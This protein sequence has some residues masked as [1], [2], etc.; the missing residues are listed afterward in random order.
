MKKLKYLMVTLLSVALFI[1]VGTLSAC[2]NEE[3]SSNSSNIET[4]NTYIEINPLKVVLDV[5]EQQ[6]LQATI[7]KGADYIFEAVTWSIADSNIAT[8]SAAGVV[9]AVSEGTTK[10]TAKYGDYEADCEIVVSNSGAKANLALADYAVEMRV[11]ETKRMA[12]IIRFKGASYTDAKFSY[13]VEDE[14]V[15]KISKSGVIEALQYGDTKV[16]VSASWRGISG[17]D[18]SLLTKEFTIKVKDDIHATIADNAYVVYQNDAEIEGVKFSNTADVEYSLTWAED[19]IKEGATLT[20]YSSDESVLRVENGKLFGVRAGTADVYCSYLSEKGDEYISNTVSVQ[21]IFPVLDKTEVMSFTIDKTT[22]LTGQEVFGTNVD[23]K[24]IECDGVSVSTEKPGAIDFD[25]MENGEHIITVY[26]EGYGYKVH[27]Y[28]CTAV[29]RTIA[30]LKA[31][32]YK[33]KNIGGGNLYALG[34]DIDGEGAVIDGASYGWS[35][36]SGFQGEIDGRGH[37]ISNITV[38]SCGIFGTLGKAKIHDINFEEITLKGVWRTA[39]FAA[40]CYNSTLENIT[41]S[42]KEIGLPI[43]ETSGTTNECGLLVSRQTNVAV[44]MRNITINAPGLSVPCVFGY[45]VGEVTFIGVVV[46][47]KEVERV[48]AVTPWA[49][50][51][52]ILETPVGVTINVG[53]EA[54]DNGNAQ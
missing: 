45:E 28:V 25:K 53:I 18:A 47:A 39:L 16:T 13:T 51:P 49:E 24:Y 36:N 42:F 10:A 8:I 38:G 4:T 22:V 31:L 50:E 27:S 34:N 5:Y 48:G 17:E 33:G 26:N 15:A 32:Q 12:P 9:S 3:S 52:T 40:T 43:H 35:Q 30:D 29:I 44:T 6:E 14:T 46:N 20:W 11:N 19:D 54:E 21:V 7:R 23:I 37:T 41:I 1:F 2:K